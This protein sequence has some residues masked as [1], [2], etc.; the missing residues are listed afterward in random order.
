MAEPKWTLLRKLPGGH[1]VF[2]DRDSKRLAIADTSGGVPDRTEDGT[3]WLHSD[4][5]IGVGSKGCSLRVIAERDNGEYTVSIT[6]EDALVLGQL[7][8]FTLRSGKSGLR[9]KLERA[10]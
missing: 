8:G 10:S 6:P 3:L 9:F 2:I 7:I 1:R 4:K 5:V